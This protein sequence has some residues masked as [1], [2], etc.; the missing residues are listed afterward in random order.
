MS[1]NYDLVCSSKCLLVTQKIVFCLQKWNI[2]LQEFTQILKLK[3]LL[4]IACIKTK[5]TYPLNVSLWWTD[6]SILSWQIAKA[7]QFGIQGL[8][9]T[10]KCIPGAPAHDNSKHFWQKYIYKLTQMVYLEIFPHDKISYPPLFPAKKL[11]PFLDALYHVWFMYHVSYI[12]YHVSFILYHVAYSM[13][14]ISCIQ[15]ESNR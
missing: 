3:W 13:H 6:S 8:M 9:D 1:N 2:P 14:N 12:M 5:N 15:D 7:W 4:P 10:C 11:P